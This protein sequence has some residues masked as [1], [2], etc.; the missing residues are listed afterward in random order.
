MLKLQILVL[1]ITTLQLYARILFIIWWF[2]VSMG[3]I[4]LR[5]GYLYIYKYISLRQ[6]TF[7]LGANLIDLNDSRANGSFI[8][9]K[10]RQSILID[11]NELFYIAK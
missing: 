1:R 2:S 3:F 6:R 11:M 7:I 8:K 4:V 9:C 10:F 5:V